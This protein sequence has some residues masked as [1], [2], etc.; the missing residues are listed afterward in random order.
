MLAVG[1]MACFKLK[2][3]RWPLRTSHLKSVHH[4][5]HSGKFLRGGRIAAHLSDLT[6][7]A[8]LLMLVTA[9]V[10]GALVSI[11]RSNFTR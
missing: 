4:Q 2:R 3:K 7:T 10:I 8:P 9:T 6:R 5:L 1:E 11:S